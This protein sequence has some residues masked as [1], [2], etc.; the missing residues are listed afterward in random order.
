MPVKE[1][2][3]TNSIIKLLK[4]VP[5][6]FVRK[7]HGSRMQGGGIPDIYFTCAAI[8]GKSVWIE[9]KR[10]EDGA[11]SPLQQHTL[12]KISRTKAITMVV[13]SKAE[14]ED[15]LVDMGIDRKALE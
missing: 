6:N 10:P 7:M 1:S 3:I 8:E 9:V 5:N 2:T 4:T 15:W 12:N 11:V 13:T 14:V